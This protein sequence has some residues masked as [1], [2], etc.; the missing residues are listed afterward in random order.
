AGFR[1]AREQVGNSE[2]R[3]HVERLRDPEGGR[4]LHEQIVRL[5]LLHR[6][7]P[8]YGV[9]RAPTAAAIL[10]IRARC[11]SIAAANS[12][13]V[14]P[15]AAMP[16]GGRRSLR[17]GLSSTAR[18]SAAMR[19]RKSDGMSRQPKKPVTPSKV[20]SGYPASAAVGT[21]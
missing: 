15:R 4:G 6:S 7:L 3:R 21:F 2:L 11:S 18:V 5:M 8:D 12:S 9:G 13:G 17:A 20:R 1:A 14:L 10:A 19:L 16:S